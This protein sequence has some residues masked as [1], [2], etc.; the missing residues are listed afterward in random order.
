MFTLLAY[1]TSSLAFLF[2][3]FKQQLI[4]NCLQTFLKQA[5]QPKPNQNPQSESETKLN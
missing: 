1:S 4:Q 3:V 5:N 2:I